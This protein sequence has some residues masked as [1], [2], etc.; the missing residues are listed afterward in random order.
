MMALAIVFMAG[1][2]AAVAP[3]RSGPLAVVVAVGASHFSADMGALLALAGLLIV[4]HFVAAF[5]ADES[6]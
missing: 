2:F 5:L 3:R 6:A 1:V 4:G